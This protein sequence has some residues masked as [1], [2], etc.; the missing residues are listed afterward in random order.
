MSSPW[1]P[2][3]L[4]PLTPIGR[5]KLVLAAIFAGVMSMIG[6]RYAPMYADPA[7]QPT[8]RWARMADWEPF[9]RGA[10]A[11]IGAAFF[12]QM[13]VVLLLLAMRR[14]TPKQASE[15]KREHSRVQAGKTP[16]SD[17]ERP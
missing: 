2:N 11:A 14:A 15:A 13:A 10:Y 7:F 12:A 6:F 4:K 8:G 5:L 16:R 9:W 1:M 17:A 3:P